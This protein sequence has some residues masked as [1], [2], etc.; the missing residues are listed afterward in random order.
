MERKRLPF[1]FRIPWKS[2]A[3]SP[4]AAA[5]SSSRRPKK[6]P[7]SPFRPPGIAPIQ[8]QTQTT[9]SP[10]RFTADETTGPSSSTS[11]NQHMKSPFKTIPPDTSSQPQKR[12]AHHPG[13]SATTL[14]TPNDSEK[15]E[16][17][18]GNSKTQWEE[19]SKFHPSEEMMKLMQNRKVE[20]AEDPVSG[21]RQV[22][23]SE[24]PE[25]VET[26]MMFATS[27]PTGKDIKVLSSTNPKVSTVSCVSPQKPL[28]ANAGKAPQQEDVSNCDHKLATGLLTQPKD[29]NPFSVTTLAGD[30]RGATMNVGSKSGKKE[31]LIPIYRAYKKNPGQ[32][33]E[34]TAEG[35]ESSEEESGNSVKN[36]IGNAYVNS[37]IQSLNNSLMCQSSINDRDPG[38]HLTLPQK[39]VEVVKLDDKQGSEIRKPEVNVRQNEGLRI[40][41]RCLRGLF[42]EPSDSDPDNPN[43]PQRHGCKYKCGST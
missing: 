43:K 29:E 5:E 8:P 32:R 25:K 13:Q 41:R 4:H 30:N 19:Q 39:H 22:Q 24:V 2:A 21:Q 28:I 18:T 38:V 6:K 33:L 1:R 36:E 14:N 40:R 42:A 12:S 16:T 3:S 34:E 26:R 35:E 37:N 9:Q 15:L 11:Q 7:K 23:Q 20:K 27:N 17:D 31:I 10:S